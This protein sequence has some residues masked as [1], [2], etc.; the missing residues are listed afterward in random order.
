MYIHTLI[1]TPSYRDDINIEAYSF[2]RSKVNMG[3]EVS[4]VELS[5]SIRGG[6]SF[7]NPDAVA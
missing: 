7:P 6:F 2:I 3:P 5:Q 4:N 1:T